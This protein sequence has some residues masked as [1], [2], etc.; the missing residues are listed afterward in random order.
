MKEWETEREFKD[1]RVVS[2]RW[3]VI[4]VDETE[5]E[6]NEEVCRVTRR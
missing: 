1:E 4:L 5:S 3:I 2:L 6:G